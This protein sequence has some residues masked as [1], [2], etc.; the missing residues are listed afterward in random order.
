MVPPRLLE[1][2]LTLM[3]EAM[4]GSSS[5]Q[6]AFRSLTSTAATA[7]NLNRWMLQFMPGAASATA[8]PE[9]FGEWLEQ[10]WKAMGVVP[11]HRYLEAL[12]RNEHLRMQL[13]TCEKTNRQL[14]NMSG[15]MGPQHEEAQ[16]AMSMWGSAMDDMLR[17]QSEWMRSL[18]PQERGSSP[19]SGPASTSTGSEEAGD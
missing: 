7:D 6:E 10:W 11:R 17:M 12:E 4:R 8:Q 9:L 18:M 3:T 19:S 15:L 2:W 1:S 5:A 13:E 16:K 14:Q